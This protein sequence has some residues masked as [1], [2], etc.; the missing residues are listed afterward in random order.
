MSLDA[1]RS[2]VSLVSARDWR[3]ATADRGPDTG[4]ARRD[5]SNSD[6]G[7]SP[8]PS[9]TVQPQRRQ[10]QQ[11]DQCLDSVTSALTQAARCAAA[12]P[13]MDGGGRSRVLISGT[14]RACLSLSRQRC[15]CTFAEVGGNS[16]QA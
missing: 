16:W 5:S 12:A 15:M 14:R 13:V 3:I 10:Q 7:P 11:K 1:R 9:Q 2:L 4:S 6:G 8:G